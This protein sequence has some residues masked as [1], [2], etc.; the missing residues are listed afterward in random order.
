M[1]KHAKTRFAFLNTKSLFC[2]H[3]EKFA[4]FTFRLFAAGSP[5]PGRSELFPARWRKFARMRLQA[6]NH[7]PSS[8]NNI[9][10]EFFH[11]F[12]AGLLCLFPPFYDCPDLIPADV[13]QFTVMFLQAFNDAPFSN[14]HI[15]A[16]FLDFIRTRSLFNQARRECDHGNGKQNRQ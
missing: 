8:R 7:A 12:R 2:S 16:K 10:A 1:I 3:P 15:L 14:T 6:F 5:R 11:I 13:R 9:R 4:T